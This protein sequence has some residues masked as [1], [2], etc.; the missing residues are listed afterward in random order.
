MPKRRELIK[1]I[2][3]A[4]K[5]AG[6]DWSWDHEGGDHTIYKLD[7]VT[8]PIKRQNEFGNRYAEIVYKE[9][10]V[11]LGKGWWRK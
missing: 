4:A 5:A 7:G 8:I 1:K 3:V 9:C 11:K 6:V 10:E 2:A